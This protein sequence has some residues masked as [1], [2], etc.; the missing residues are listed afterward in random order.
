[1]TGTSGDRPLRVLVVDDNLAHARLITALVEECFAG[2][3]VGHAGRLSTALR[4]LEGEDVD[5]VLLDLFLPDAQGMTT[6]SR[7]VHQAGRV[8]VIVVTALD[9]GATIDDALRLGAADVLTKDTLDREL[10]G[11]ALDRSLHRVVSTVPLFDGASTIIGRDA[12]CWMAGRQTKFVTRQRLSVTLV[13]L[14]PAAGSPVTPLQLAELA[15]QTFRGSDIIGRVSERHVAVLLPDDATAGHAPLER[16]SSR[17]TLAMP[18][19]AVGDHIASTTTTLGPDDAQPIEQLLPPP[20]ERSGSVPLPKRVVVALADESAALALEAG[21]RTI[22]DVFV[23]TS[24][25][26]LLR[27]AALED[28]DA[29]VVDATL[30][31]DA[32]DTVRR[33]RQQAETRSV[34]V[35]LAGNS[36]TDQAASRQMGFAGTFA[37]TPASLAPDAAARVIADVTRRSER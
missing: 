7:V 10:L 33:L 6:L 16:L 32:G 2:A 15:E 13:L 23:A 12:F 8:P 21:L 35:V 5:A 25:A 28:V 19:L 17:L 11:H 26:E 9:D 3:Q 24:P 37:L 30:A 14:A 18:H 4:R 20:G 31:G 1:M 34:P 27:V 22:F 36:E 29:I